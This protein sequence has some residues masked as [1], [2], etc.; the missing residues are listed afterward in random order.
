MLTLVKL[1]EKEN[2][3]I[4]ILVTLLR[5]VTLVRLLQWENALSPMLVTQEGMVYSPGGYSRI[6][7]AAL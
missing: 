7:V 3:L 6:L 4:P 5:I 1:L 2:A